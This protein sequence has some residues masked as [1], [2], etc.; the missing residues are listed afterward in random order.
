MNKVTS[1]SHG[2][3]I[4]VR[5]RLQRVTL[6]FVTGLLTGILV[7]LGVV[8][9]LRAIRGLAAFFH[10]PGLAGG[11]PLL[12]DLQIVAI[13]VLGGLL[14]ALLLRG[15]HRN[16]SHSLAEVLAAVQTGQGRI[17]PRGG[18]QSVLASL[19]ALGSGASV[20]EYGPLAHFGGTVGSQLSRLIRA[21]YWTGNTAIACGVAA[22]ISAAFNAPIAGILF[23][24]EVVL[25]HFALSAFAPVAGAALVAW[26]VTQMMV[27]RPPLLLV[28]TASVSHYGEYG[29]FVLMGAL[30][31]L[32][33]VG[34][35]RAILAVD[36]WSLRA[37]IP[38]WL[39]PA[40]AGLALGVAA[41]W[42]PEILGTGNDTLRAAIIDQRFGV[43]MLSLLLIGKLTASV[44]CLGMGFAGGFFGPA[45]VS[46]A[47]YGALFGA[48]AFALIGEQ[49][50]GL[51]VYGICGMVAVAS[52]VIGAPLATVLIVFELT[53]N[54]TVTL[55][56][57]ASVAVSNLIAYRFFGRSLFDV[58]LAGR[59]LDL[60]VGRGK[61]MLANSQLRELVSQDYLSIPARTTVSQALGLMAQ[62]RHSE[63]YVV[64]REGHYVG[65]LTLAQLHHAE[66]DAGARVVDELVRTD[67]PVLSAATS[68][69]EAMDYLKTFVGQAVPVLESGD[70]RRMLGVV[71]ES[72]LVTAYLETL[73]QVRREEHGA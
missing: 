8:A 39:Q 67:W 71:S 34:Y 13:P 31:A 11:N 10:A 28:E 23:V 48:A 20:G 15:M 30:G 49:H 17:D 3:S 64:D 25:R 26:L 44:V 53:H 19:V 12:A 73:E 45:L 41:L 7:A 60:S 66:P 68:V 55:A 61:A 9:F 22:A 63:A 37:P 4:S 46:G 47:L 70:S 6:L 33:A 43:D 38:A 18:A 72:A 24:H 36:A 50:A 32:L 59:G 57:L 29:L 52:P 65:A 54:Y 16:R 21:R 35:M 62:K 14:V 40:S 69:W 1:L 5:L 42:L 2:A 27:P 58:Q 51:A 56:A